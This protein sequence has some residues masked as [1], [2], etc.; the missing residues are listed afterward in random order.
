MTQQNCFAFPK[1]SRF[2]KEDFVVTSSNEKAYRM[3]EAWPNGREL[4][5]AKLMLLCGPEGSGKS[6]LTHIWEEK[7][8]AQRWE[9]NFLTLPGDCIRYGI[10]ENIDLIEDEESL[11]H[12]INACLDSPSYMLLTSAFPPMQMRVILPD[13]YSRLQAI[14]VAQI[15]APD[16]DLMQVLLEKQC[17]DRQLR[18]GGDVLRYVIARMD[19]SYYAIRAMAEKLEALSLSMQRPITIPLLKKE[20]SL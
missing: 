19:R 9:A 2:Y 5:F 8:Q 17:S 15:E 18:I 7:H 12:V 16:D 3:L 10:I 13:L 14:P 6:H 1:E 11:L 4:G 20:C